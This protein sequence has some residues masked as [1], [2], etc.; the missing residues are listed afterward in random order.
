M[1]I[2]NDFSTALLQARQ[3]KGVTQENIAFALNISHATYNA[4]ECGHRLCPYKHIISLINY[5]DDDLFTRRMLRILLALQHNMAGLSGKSKTETS[6][7]Y[8]KI[9]ALLADECAQWLKDIDKH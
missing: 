2:L 7:F 6:A 9:I 4:W 8:M 1:N 3:R 5:F